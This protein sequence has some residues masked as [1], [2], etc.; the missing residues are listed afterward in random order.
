MGRNTKDADRGSV[1]ASLPFSFAPGI[2]VNFHLFDARA[3]SAHDRSSYARA[4]A[5][6]GCILCASRCLDMHSAFISI[7]RNAVHSPLHIAYMYIYTFVIYAL[8][9]RSRIRVVILKKIRYDPGSKSRCIFM[10][11]VR[12]TSRC[13]KMKFKSITRVTRRSVSSSTRC[14]L[15]KM[16]SIFIQVL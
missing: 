13:I 5:R 2:S 15:N 1:P 8:K 11:L 12:R 10:A 14:L 4:R 9:V 7:L 16:F 6:G 3:F